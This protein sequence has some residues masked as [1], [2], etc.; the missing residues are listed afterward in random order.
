M[1]IWKC[2]ATIVA[3]IV[4]ASTPVLA[5]TPEQMAEALDRKVCPRPAL[6]V[7][8]PRLADYCTANAKSDCQIRW[9][10]DFNL[11]QRY[12]TMMRACARSS[13]SGADSTPSGSK[14]AGQPSEA[15]KD[16]A[17]DP[18]VE[19]PKASFADRLKSAE[20]RKKYS[21]NRA[22]DEAAR[23]LLEQE[24]MDEIIKERVLAHEER[25]AEQRELARQLKE[26]EAN[27]QR[28]QQKIDAEPKSPSIYRWVS[29]PSC[30]T[31]MISATRSYNQCIQTC[32]NNSCYERDCR[33]ECFDAAI[34]YNGQACE[35][36]QCN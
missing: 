12:N 36:V 25:L 6:E 2:A 26:H 4:L 27:Q 8:S 32:S 3:S 31:R 20:A 23:I 19:Q 18:G 22:A 35:A 17:G 29:I 5:I 34:R 21:T 1:G 11:T 14:P 10:R 24:R 13:T 15:P 7:E 16:T 30:S 28:M 33:T 9:N